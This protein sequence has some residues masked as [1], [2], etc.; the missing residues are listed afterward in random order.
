MQWTGNVGRTVGQVLLAL[1]IIAL[2]LGI[3]GLLTGVFVLGKA[4]DNPEMQDGV[5][6]IL[7]PLVMGG[8]ALVGFGTVA[9]VGAI[10]ILGVARALRERLARQLAAAR[11]PVIPGAPDS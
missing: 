3:L 10:I 6:E 4:A 9:V 5:G 11:P 7:E 1:G 2:V 8:M